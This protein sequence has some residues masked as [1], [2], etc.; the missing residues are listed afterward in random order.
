MDSSTVGVQGIDAVCADQGFGQPILFVHGW[1]GWHQYWRHVWPRFVPRFRTLACDLPGFGR[2]EKPDDRSPYTME[3]YA[4]WIPALL[5]AKQVPQ[6]ILVG[7]SMGGMISLLAASRHPER[8]SK[9]ILINPMVQGATGMN[10]RTRFLSGP[11]IRTVVYALTKFDGGL[12][13]VAEGFTNTQPMAF[14]DLES[15][16]MA[17]FRAMSESLSSMRE[18]DALD[19][20]GR[21]TT[22]T[23]VVTATEDR[24]ID[25]AQGASAARAI[26]GSAQVRLASV[27]HCVQLEAP[28]LLAATLLEWLSDVPRPMRPRQ[29]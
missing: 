28:A 1:G 14:E 2:G 21:V 18:T 24:V 17:S 4:D 10:A 7:H 25:P 19:A 3:W 12:A 27:G 6:A 9:L 5:D 26:A 23:L 29:W 22:P 15:M 16:R 8:F 20:A 11:V 13:L